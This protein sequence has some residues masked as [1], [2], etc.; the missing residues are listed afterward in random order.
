MSLKQR[1]FLFSVVLMLIS[2]LA[3]WSWVR[4]LAEEI[5]EQWA[6][7]YAQTQVLYDRQRTLQPL[8]RELALSRQLA[9]SPD[10][11]RFARQ[12]G[13]PDYRKAA[14]Q[15]M[16][17]FR[18]NFLQMNYFVALAKTG[19]Y[20]HNDANNTYQNNPLRYRLNP[21]NTKDAWF[22]QLI[23]EQR[24]LHVNI[25]HDPE[26]NATKLWINI[27]L[28]DN[29]EPLGV[30][31]TGLN[32]SDLITRTTGDA[33]RGINNIFV[34][35]RGAIQLHRDPAMMNFSSLTRD[36][37]QFTTLHQ[38]LTE[39]ADRAELR[40][41]MDASRNRP[42]RV[43]S[44]YVETRDGRQLMAVAYLPEIEWHEI[45]LIDINRF[46]PMDRF[47]GIFAIYALTFGLMILLINLA[48]RYLIFRPINRLEEAMAAIGR[49][50]ASP[51]KLHAQGELKTLSR[52]I[53]QLIETLAARQQEAEERLRLQTQS[54]EHARY[55]DPLTGCLNRQGMLQQL[56]R[57]STPPYRAYSLLRIQLE[58]LQ[59]INERYGYEQ[60]DK[61]L[62]RVAEALQDAI[63]STGKG[64]SSRWGSACFL[65]VSP[66]TEPELLQQL[67]EELCRSVENQIPEY[68]GNGLNYIPLTLSIGL[69]LSRPEDDLFQAIHHADLALQNAQRDNRQRIALFR[70]PGFSLSDS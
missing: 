22:Y 44:R 53:C 21:D 12:P 65:V 16:E 60:G 30:V 62:C 70:Q 64:Y 14:L 24:P 25:N 37:G 58:L 23:R 6:L 66:R 61:A 13:N 19:D 5:I 31:G 29:G 9:Q 11:I 69:Y 68:A 18:F 67:A 50:D 54:L 51:Q 59:E 40:R 49:G 45:T 42:D 46:L 35:Q 26:L 48:L 8:T 28:T 47:T 32:L 55:T 43:I 56:Q 20:F 57:F 17:N 1:F 36:N 3:T 41:A 2:C 38:L 33:Q 15:E 7:R 10:L 27:L 4:S 39:E 52:H 63:D 34:D